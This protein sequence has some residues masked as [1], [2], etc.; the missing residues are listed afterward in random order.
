M[1]CARHDTR[2]LECE[3]PACDGAAS[4]I[5]LAFVTAPVTSRIVRVF[6]CCEGTC[7]D[8]MAES[9]ELDGC[10]VGALP[11]CPLPGVDP[12]VHGQRVHRILT[13]LVGSDRLAK[14][15]DAPE[16]I[17]DKLELGCRWTMGVIA[18]LRATSHT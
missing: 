7:L 15:C 11:L 13:G 2:S 3:N 10:S 8:D 6:Y 17:T 9:H 16:A 4:C 18:D 1:N 12:L 14:V 5:A